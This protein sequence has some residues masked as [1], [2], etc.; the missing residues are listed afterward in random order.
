MALTE[1]KIRYETLIRWH[2]DGKIGA[3]QIDLEQVLRDGVV[4]SSTP[5]MAQTLATADFEGAVSLSEILGE[6]ATA[7]LEQVEALTISLAE[8]NVIAAQQL[9]EISQLRGDLSSARS[10][11]DTANSLIED[12]IREVDVPAELESKDMQKV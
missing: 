3:H 8:A 6:V 2:E 7:A 11:L 4:I 12:L 9:D 10:D 5:T 1:R